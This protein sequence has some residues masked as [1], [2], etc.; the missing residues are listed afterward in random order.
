[1][2]GRE[3][4]KCRPDSSDSQLGAEAGPVRLA[5]ARAQREHHG[6]RG[7]E[8]RGHDA[9]NDRR[10]GKVE[11]PAERGTGDR[12][13]L[14]GRGTEREC[15]AELLA[16]HD[17]RQQRLSGRHRERTR[18]AE[19]QH[20]AEHRQ[21]TLQSAQREREQQQRAQALERIAGGDDAPPIVV[22]GDVTGRQH[23]HDE[24]QELRESNQAQV[25]RIARD[26]VDLPADRD[27]L[28]LHRERR[29]QAR[30]EVQREFA[31][32]QHLE[33]GGATPAHARHRVVASVVAA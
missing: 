8:Q 2:V 30:A 21:C 15:R 11:Q 32:A 4:T 1:M 20:H 17:V 29:E 12:R 10:A 24:G 26:F 6:D 23:E 16:R 3:R 13:Q 14:P 28:G 5:P 9:I 31:L 33:S 25:E 22:V 7:G 27:R 18:D 19:Q